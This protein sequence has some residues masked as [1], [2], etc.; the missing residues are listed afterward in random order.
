MVLK[1]ESEDSEEQSIEEN[2]ENDEKIEGNNLNERVLK[3]IEEIGEYEYKK[4]NL[5]VEGSK[6][7]E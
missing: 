1:E 6:Y 4:D 7:R 5:E 3:I 2:E